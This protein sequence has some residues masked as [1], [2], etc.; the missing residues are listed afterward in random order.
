MWPRSSR[1]WPWMKWCNGRGWS[2]LLTVVT[3]LDQCFNL[4]VYSWPPH[5]WAAETFHFDMLGCPSC[6]SWSTCCWPC[7]GITTWEF[8]IIQPSSD[9]SSIFRF[10]NSFSSYWGQTLGQ[11]CCMYV[12][13]WEWTGSLDVQFS[14]CLLVTVESSRHFS[15]T[16]S[17]GCRVVW[18]ESLSGS[19]LN[20]SALA[21]SVL[22]SRFPGECI[23]VRWQSQCPSL[24]LSWSLWRNHLSL[25]SD[26][27]SGLWCYEREMAAIHTSEI[28]PE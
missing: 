21:C 2:N 19:L 11:P 6:N 25:L 16:H 4:T 20:P 10:Q 1:P 12:N 23:F 5:E 14:I 27:S 24:N 15:N 17:G 8:H 9:A 3:F 7:F 22:C 13:T 26:V 18:G 28:H